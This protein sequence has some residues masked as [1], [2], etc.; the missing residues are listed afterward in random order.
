VAHLDFHTGLGR[1]GS[2]KLLYDPGFTPGLLDRAGRWFGR[3]HLQASTPAGVAYRVRGGFGP[4]CVE[5]AGGRDY[6]FL[7]AEFG[8][9]GNV[10]VLAAVRAENRAHHWGRPDAPTTRWAKAR[11]REVFCPASSAWRVRVVADALRVIDRAVT[12]LSA[13]A[14]R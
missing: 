9:Y 8:T 6:L 7:C 4:W 10:T 13:E 12:G 11:L 14:K 5:R 2:Y 3:D 1:R